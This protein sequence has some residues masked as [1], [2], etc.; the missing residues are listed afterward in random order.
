[1]LSS[2]RPGSS[3]ATSTGARSRIGSLTSAAS[4]ATPT[5]TP[6]TWL[7][8]R[9]RG[10]HHRT[11][12]V[13]EAEHSPGAHLSGRHSPVPGVRER[14]RVGPG[15]PAALR[16]PP[17]P[18]LLRGNTAAPTQEF[19]GRPAKRA[20][21][22]AEQ[23]PGSKIE[24]DFAVTMVTGHAEFDHLGFAV[25]VVKARQNRTLPSRCRSV[26]PGP[27]DGLGCLFVRCTGLT[28]LRRHRFAGLGTPRRAAR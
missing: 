13:L 14:S 11:A 1:M 17:V 6:W 12:G 4:S 9:H 10:V 26:P 16:Q 25:P 24:F 19:E 23:S 3:P 28:R 18:D 15:L 8:G 21:T 2:C 22:K 7:P 20:L 5:A 27:R